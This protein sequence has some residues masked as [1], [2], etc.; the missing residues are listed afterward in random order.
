VKEG[1]GLERLMRISNA[2]CAEKDAEDAIRQVALNVCST[3]HPA[4]I[5]ISRVT[6]DMNFEHF[7]S[8]GVNEDA[9]QATKT[10]DAFLI[11]V[12]NQALAS[13]EIFFKISTKLFWRVFL[14]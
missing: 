5:Y 7:L 9:R 2:L 8:F 4:I 10:L 3:G 11:P 14:M 1:L 12:L 6:K 13:D